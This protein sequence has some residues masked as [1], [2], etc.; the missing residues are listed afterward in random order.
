M[1]TS[2]TRPAV[3]VGPRSARP[4]LALALGILSVPGTTLAWDLPGGGY[5]IGLPLSVAAIVLGVRARR[6]RVRGTGAKM[7]TTAIVLAV[8][9]IGQMAIWSTVSALSADDK[10]TTPAAATSHEA[11][12]APTRSSAPCGVH[13]DG[14]GMTGTPCPAGPTRRP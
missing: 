11:T 13:Y 3:D 12:V 5:W 7:A 4:G 10:A 14:R 9:S 8:L 2:A 1:Q 6:A